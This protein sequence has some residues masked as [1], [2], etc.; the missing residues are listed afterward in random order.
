MV[1]GIFIDRL[2]AENALSKLEAS[3]YNP[4]DISIMMKDTREARHFASDTGASVASGTIS[5][6]ATGGVL[7]AL[8]GLLVAT[9]VFPGLGTFLIGGPLA[10]SLG[11]TGAAAAAVSGAATGALA[12]G[13]IGALIGFGVPEEDARVYQASLKQ[14]G[15]LVIVPARSG[16]ETEVRAILE[17]NG[18]TQIR[19]VEQT[20]PVVRIEEEGYTPAYFSEVRRKRK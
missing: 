5:G 9:G 14:G 4:R 11:L 2:G 3:G 16:E 19:A 13:V 15:I 7:G 8:A 20:E 12:G 18:A 1:L 17:E 6:A 10:I